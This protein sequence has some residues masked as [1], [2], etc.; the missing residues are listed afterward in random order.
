MKTCYHCGNEVVTTEEIVYKDKSFCCVG[1]H[2][3]YEI[4]TDNNLTDYYS[5]EKNPGTSPKSSKSNFL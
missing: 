4:L 2:T 5:F 3:V 1:C